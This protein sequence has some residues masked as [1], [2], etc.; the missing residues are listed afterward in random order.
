MS[1]KIYVN[2]EDIIKLQRAFTSMQAEI[3]QYMK[4]GTDDIVKSAPEGGQRKLMEENMEIVQARSKELPAAVEGIKKEL[5]DVI[6]SING[7]NDQQLTKIISQAADAIKSAESVAAE[8]SA[9]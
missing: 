2:E 7:F 4:V 3:D 1:T 5:Y 6:K 9:L 8:G